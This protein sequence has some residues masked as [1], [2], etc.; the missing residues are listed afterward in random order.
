M[1]NRNFNHCYTP[2]NSIAVDSFSQYVQFD[3]LPHFV[4]LKSSKRVMHL[5]IN[6]NRIAN[7]HVKMLYI[8]FVSI[9]PCCCNQSNIFGVGNDVVSILAAYPAGNA[10]GIFS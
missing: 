1:Q 10:R 5:F 4:L 6:D 7:T 9:L 8:S 3:R 2:N